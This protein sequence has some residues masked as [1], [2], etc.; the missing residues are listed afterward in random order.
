MEGLREEV[1]MKGENIECQREIKG[2]KRRKNYE[3]LKIKSRKKKGE[4]HNKNVG[5]LNLK[6]RS[7]INKCINK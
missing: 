4:K 1:G 3:A 6:K 7:G 2:R 5:R